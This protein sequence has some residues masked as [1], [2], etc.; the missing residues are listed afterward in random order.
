VCVSANVRESPDR[1]A[2]VAAGV[3][4]HL[5]NVNAKDPRVAEPVRHQ[6]RVRRPAAGGA[7]WPGR[8]WADPTGA[9]SLIPIGSATDQNSSDVFGTRPVSPPNGKDNRIGLQACR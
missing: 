3:A 5:H 6:R 7:R 8:L 4:S 1:V 2:D 9:R